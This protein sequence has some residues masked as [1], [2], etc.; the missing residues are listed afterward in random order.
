MNFVIFIMVLFII[1]FVWAL[2]SL[3]HEVRKPKEIERAK[4]YLSK[5]KVLFKAS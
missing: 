1:S 5:E 3:I 4:E 2:Y